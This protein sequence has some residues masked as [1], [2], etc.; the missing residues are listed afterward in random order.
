MNDYGGWISVMV[1]LPLVAATLCFLIG[2]RRVAWIAN[3]T[4]PVLVVGA[5]VLADAVGQGEVV[6]HAPGGW[7]AP[8]G[9]EWRL[10]GAGALMMVVTALVGW[11]VSLFAPGYETHGD[12]ERAP[13]RFWPPFL[14]LWAG[15]NALYLAADVFNLFVCLELIAMAAVVL[16]ALEGKEA[17]VTA[18]MRYLL[19]AQV[20]SL[21]YLIGVGFLYGFGT[22]DLAQLGAAVQEGTPA[23][24]ALALMTAGLIAKAALF[25]MH[26]WLPPAHSAAP[27]H[28]S[29]LLSGLVIAASVL[30][31]LR[32]WDAVFGVVS[33]EAVRQFVGAI[34]AVS[35]L[36]GS[37][38]ALRQDRLKP[39]LAYSTVAQTG[40][41]LLLI[42]L[43]GTV[44]AW[45]GGVLLL[46]A[47]AVAKAAMFLAAGLIL[48]AL[49]T[50]RLSSIHGAVRRMPL[51]VFALGI[52]G[53]T[54]MGLPPS[55]GF[56]AKWLLLGAALA[57]GQWWW[58]VVL[59][60][61][62]LL[63]AGYVFAILAP[64][65]RDAS[66]T[67]FTPVSPWMQ[68]VPLV[69]ATVSLLMGLAGGPMARLL[70]VGTP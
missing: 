45:S 66:D 25:P 20:G 38:A 41:L 33:G 64:A 52:G 2:G 13:G 24:L 42:P 63:A 62:G 6:R 40:Y 51:T 36:W 18:A 55:G 21:C 22:L 44:G 19:L 47:H 37:V 32:L 34:G 29:A 28:A 49:G 11:A 53:L 60:L 5:A 26:V 10:D 30:V 56:L 23:G 70:E 65:F 15:L 43:A 54:L 46:A 9:I 16:V 35:V 7:G 31:L 3:L 67:P 58:A 59:V 8:L 14:M 48:E 68:G 61:G 27:S 1:A 69:L 39:L 50:D 12:L 57:G 4:A 17:A